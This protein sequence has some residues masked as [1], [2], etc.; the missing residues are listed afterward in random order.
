MSYHMEWQFSAACSLLSLACLMDCLREGSQRRGG[1][2]CREED[3]LALQVRHV[4][5]ACKTRRLQGGVGLKAVIISI[6][7]LKCLE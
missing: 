5:A 7:A 6:V 3:W 2:P 4:A 1:S